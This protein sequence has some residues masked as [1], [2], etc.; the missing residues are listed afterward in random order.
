MGTAE[1]RRFPRIDHVSP[2]QIVRVDD[3]ENPQ[4]NFVITENLSGSGIKFTT[5]S[6]LKSS[7]YF[8]VYLNDALLSD[9]GQN[10]ENLLKSGDYYLCKVVWSNEIR[11]NAYEVGAAFLEKKSCQSQDIDTFTEL[12]NITMLDLLPELSELS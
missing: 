1:N 12:V 2:R 6:A 3:S 5:N 11:S 9:I 8:L 7:S 10:S 4:K